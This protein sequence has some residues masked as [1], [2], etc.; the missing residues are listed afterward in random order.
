MNIT[1]I[2][3]TVTI[4]LANTDKKDVLPVSYHSCQRFAAFVLAESA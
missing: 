2:F 1:V 3:L 4:F